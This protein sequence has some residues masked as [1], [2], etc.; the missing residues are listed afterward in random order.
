M[1]GIYGS[2]V[3]YNDQIITKKLAKVNFRGP[4]HV[5]FERMGNLVLGHNRLAII[6]IDARSNQPFTYIHLKI[7]FNGEI[8]NYLELRLALSKKGFLFYTNSDTEVL[9]AAYLAYGNNCVTHLNGMFSF[10]IYDNHKKTLFGARDRLGKK[11]FYYA[12]NGIDFEFASQPSQIAYHRDVTTDQHAISEFFIWGYIPEPRSQWVEIK[13]LMAGHSFNFNLTTGVLN[14]EKYW[15]IDYQHK[16]HFFGNYAEA[17]QHLDN[18]VTD[19]VRIRLHADVDLGVFLSG[20][21]D[22]SLIAAMATKKTERIKTFCVK[23]RESGFDESSHAEA[24]A[25]HLCTQHHTI[26]CHATDGIDLISQYADFYDEPF[27]DPSAIPTLLLNKYT[28]SRVTVALGGD[29]GDESFMGYQRYIWLNRANRMFNYPLA[30]RKCFAFPLK[31]SANYRHRLVA[32]GMCQTDIASLY[33]YMLG[34]LNYDW[35]KN[36]AAG[37]N[38]PFMN[39]WNEMDGSLLRKMSVFDLKTYLNG[40][41]NTKVD[42][43]SMAYAVEARSP[44][45]DHRIVD[46]ALSLPDHFKINGNNQKRILKDVLYRYVPEHY[47]RRSKSGFSVPL[48]HYLSSIN[49]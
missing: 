1:C 32:E 49:N 13:K 26:E 41:I 25:K 10:V 27:A 38:V 35:L 16:N 14:T 4:D 34:G 46:F 24:V 30:I 43:G 28:K 48:R 40:D 33:T 18:L 5:A 11:P 45:M 22:S 19:A 37:I 7:V 12:H 20:G 6:D 29:G 36:P 15:D 9:A 17:V 47:F 8:Y 21:I 31:L 23:F 42:R 2:T 39:I 44:L 3:F